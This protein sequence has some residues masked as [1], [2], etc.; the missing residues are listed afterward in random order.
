[1]TLLDDAAPSVHHDR[2]RDRSSCEDIDAFLAAAFT[3]HRAQQLLL[4]LTTQSRDVAR[5][6]AQALASGRIDAPGLEKAARAGG[7]QAVLVLVHNSQ[8]T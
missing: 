1:M 4:T 2:P 6:A 3:Q 7:R 8:G 5:L